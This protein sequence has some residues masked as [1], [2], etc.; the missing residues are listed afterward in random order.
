MMVELPDLVQRARIGSLRSYEMSDATITILGE[1]AVQSVHGITAAVGLGEL[2]PHRRMAVDCRRGGGRIPLVSASL[3]AEHRV[4]D[5]HR[6]SVFLLGPHRRFGIDIPEADYAQ[7]TT[8]KRLVDY[9][10]AGCAGSPRGGASP[11]C[12]SARCV[13]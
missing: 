9:T 13:A 1:Q 7:L 6:G 8:I 11:R 4:S 3:A 5:G 2:W 10:A 12:C